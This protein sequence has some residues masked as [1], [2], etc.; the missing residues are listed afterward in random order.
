MDKSTEELIKEGISKGISYRA[1]RELVQDLVVE[2]KATGPNQTADL[3]NYTK[4]NDRRM[5][6]WDKVFNIDP[7]SRQIIQNF[8]K[9]VTW[10]VLTES[11][12]GDAAPALPVMDKIASLNPNIQLKV[13]LRDENSQLM[14]K[15][16]TNGGMSIPKLIVINDEDMSVVADWGPR[17]KNA[18]QLVTEHKA[19]N[20]G[21]ILP[22]FK[23]D[24]QL[25]YNKDKGE[26]IL[27]E[28][29]ALE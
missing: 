12:C 14:G 20:K 5:A 13:I 1:Y 29:L 9:K 26:S 18:A 2:G 25:W 17:S 24:L 4:L 23:Q 15:F 8:N 11:W 10:L 7:K 22:E 28:L 21:N 3:A 16:L 19:A 6:R 27:A